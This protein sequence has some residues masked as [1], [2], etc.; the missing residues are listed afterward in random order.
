MK[1]F[2]Q[3]FNPIFLFVLLLFSMSISA[4]I[5]NIP[6]ANLKTALVNY[7]NPVI[8]TNGDSE[9]QVS[10]AEAVINGLYL[11]SSNI[12]DATGIEA[13]INVT[14]LNLSYNH[15]TSI[16]LSNFPDL[17]FL[18]ISS[19]F[20][21]ELDISNNSNLTTLA[22][23]SN[24]NLT[25]INLKN[26]NMENMELLE[27]LYETPN[28]NL[29]CVD[30]VNT[31]YDIMPMWPGNMMWDALITT[32]CSFTP[33]QSN[34][35]TGN[36]NLDNGQGCLD[37]TATGF[38]NTLVQAVQGP[39][40]FGVWTDDMGNYDLYVDTGATIT[41]V[42]SNLPPYFSVLPASHSSNFTGY[43]TTE[44][45]DFC[46]ES[47]SQ[48]DDLNVTIIPISFAQ[49]G[50][51]TVYKIVYE[52]MGSTV[53]SGQIT[54]QYDDS[55]QTFVL[56]TP[57][58]TSITANILN[59]DFT[60]LLP[61]HS[62]EIMV[63]MLNGIPPA[64]ELGDVLT[65]TATITPNTNDYTPNDNTFQLEQTVVSS[66]DPNDKQVLE[67]EEIAIADADEYLHYLIRFQNT[68]TASAN[69]V[70]V[71][72][73][74]SEMLDW[75]SLRMVSSSHEFRA[76]TTNGNFVEFIFEG[77]NLPYESADEPGSHGY[78]AFKI[79]PKTDIAVGDFITG[80]AAIYFDFNEPIITNTV[81]T[82]VVENLS[83]ESFNLTENISLYPNPT[84]GILNISTEKDVQN[85]EVYSITGKL[86]FQHSGDLKNIDL[87]EFARGVYFLKIMG[88]NGQIFTEKIIRK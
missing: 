50:E 52:N 14:F 18:D 12:S 40:S 27:P 61:L 83:S 53:L 76:R 17:A 57:T 25:Y 29:V 9:I 26:G 19:N 36:L 44:T 3:I 72:D 24:P 62:R 70:V 34:V 31:F 6:D 87:Q 66:F 33:A 2:Y 65:F 5:V 80:K 56:A 35:L 30:D 81:S 77:I 46:I 10:E 8:D 39:N 1:H 23:L 38:P 78:I 71:T 63:E 47:N 67:G 85:L 20:L 58:E 82:E 88:E 11:G 51:T 15:L 28:V 68:G 48:V 45:V 84:N 64:V 49:P 4:Q 41:S 32:Y 54:F 79:K 21:T 42:V 73:T 60:D 22:F 37:P 69:N 16:N 74:L 55:K 7:Q 75:S 13:F 86:L 59:F 43:G